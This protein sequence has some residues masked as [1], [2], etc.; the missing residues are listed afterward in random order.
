MTL[1]SVIQLI[2]PK[3]ESHA[4]HKIWNTTSQIANSNFVCKAQSFQIFNFTRYSC[5]CRKSHAWMSLFS[6]NKT[7]TDASM[8]NASRTQLQCQRATR[9]PAAP[10]CACSCTARASVTP[11]ASPGSMTQEGHASVSLPTLPLFLSSRRFSLS[12]TANHRAYPQYSCHAI[13]MRILI[14]S[15]TQGWIFCFA[16]RIS[17]DLPPQS[18]KFR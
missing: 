11:S 7:S 15:S 13:F 14:S 5:R 8:Q 10:P 6:R 9:S 17:R 3:F 4:R 12:E 16:S 1:G 2:A 18:H